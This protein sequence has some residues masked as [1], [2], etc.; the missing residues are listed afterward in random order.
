VKGPEISVPREARPFQGESA[1]VVTRFVANSIDAAVVAAAVGGIYLGWC[2]LVFMLD[3]RAFEFPEVSFLASLTVALGIAV[4]YLWLAWWLLGQSYGGHIMGIRVSG[5]RGRKLGPLRSLAR[6]WFCV[7]FPIGLF[8][9]VVSPHRRSVQDAVL[10]TKVV[11]DWLPRT[12]AEVQPPAE[13][14]PSAAAHPASLGDPAGRRP[15]TDD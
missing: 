13:G 7:L 11:Y 5:R 14:E 6:A 1:G 2:V 9:C 15:R 4:F 12:V 10:F 8:W 3:P